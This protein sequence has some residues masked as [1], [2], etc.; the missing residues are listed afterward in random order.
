MTRFNELAR[1]EAAIEHHN[2]GDLR[3]ALGYCKMRL[4]ISVRKEHIKYW[5]QIENNVIQALENS[6]LPST[7]A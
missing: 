6:T 2:E 3:W 5:K 7:P 1:I 4:S